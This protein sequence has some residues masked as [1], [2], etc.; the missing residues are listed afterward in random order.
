LILTTQISLIIITFLSSIIISSQEVTRE[1]NHEKYLEWELMR[2]KNVKTVRIY[3]R[4]EDNNK[5]KLSSI[6]E[7]EKSGKGLSYYYFDKDSIVTAYN[8]YKYSNDTLIEENAYYKYFR[9]EI[10]RTVKYIYNES[11]QL[12]EQEYIEDI[13]PTKTTYFYDSNNVLIKSIYCLYSRCHRISFYI[14]DEDNILLKEEIR[15]T[16]NALI[17]E[18]LYRD[19][20]KI[21]T[22]RHFND[23][24]SLVVISNNFGDEIEFLDYSN[25]IAERRTITSRNENGYWESVIKYRDDKIETF[26]YRKF[27]DFKKI[28]LEERYDNGKLQYR[29]ITDYDANGLKI[30]ETIK[31]LKEKNNKISIYTYYPNGLMKSINRLRLNDKSEYKTKFIYDYYE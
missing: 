2:S 5:Y 30:R 15:D 25:G 18:Y 9:P 11:N 29:E 24:D 16:N 7:Y 4:G 14:Y 27:N 28:V 21:R 26:Q 17:E 23:D 13:D 20:G 3:N 22:R 12:I 8:T 6:K 1:L 10:N 31:S 19:N